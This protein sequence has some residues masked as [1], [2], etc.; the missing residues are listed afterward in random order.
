VVLDGRE[1]KNLSNAILKGKF[2]GTVVSDG[3]KKP[4]PV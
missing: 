4:L 1:P 3:K 2:R